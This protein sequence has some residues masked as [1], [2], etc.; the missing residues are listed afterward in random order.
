MKEV[1]LDCEMLKENHKDAGEVISIG[2]I[3]R[4]NDTY[5]SLIQT[6]RPI[7]MPTRLIFLTGI[8]DSMLDTAP[9]FSKVIS[10]VNSF[11]KDFDVIY[12]FGCADVAALTKT[13]YLNDAIYHFDEKFKEKFKEIT[14]KIKD[15]R[16]EECF[17]EFGDKISLAE[18]YEQTMGQQ[19]NA[20]HNALEDAKNLKIIYDALKEGIS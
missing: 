17:E 4:N 9:V 14:R 7:L 12:T 11:T 20:S 19:I 3:S 16:K 15:I 2:M 13:F 5:Y 8:N 6:K 18:I 1:F 10:E